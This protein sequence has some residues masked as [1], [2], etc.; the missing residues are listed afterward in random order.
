MQPVRGRWGLSL[1]QHHANRLVPTVSD[2]LK[3]QYSPFCLVSTLVGTPHLY[4]LLIS[5]IYL[6]SVLDDVFSSHALSASSRGD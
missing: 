1:D 4:A 2:K 3:F 5:G 6:L